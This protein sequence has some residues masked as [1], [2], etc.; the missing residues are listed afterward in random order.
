MDNLLIKECEDKFTSIIVPW[1][2]NDVVLFGAWCLMRKVPTNSLSTIGISTKSKDIS[3]KYNPNFVKTVSKEFLEFVMV[4]ETLKILL[5]HPTTRLVNPP[6]VSNIA[7]KITINELLCNSNGSSKVNDLIKESEGNKLFDSFK[8]E[9][10]QFF[11]E[12]F[13]NVIDQFDEPKEEKL[14]GMF[15]KDHGKD[16]EGCTTFGSSNE[17][18]KEYT[19]PFNDSTKEWGESK[20]FDETMKE[21]VDRHKNSSKSWGTYTGNCQGEILAATQSGV[22]YRT[23][24]SSFAQSVRKDDTYSS[25]MRYNRRHGLVVPG[26][27]K[28]EI[29]KIIVAIDESGS[30]SDADIA[31]G[32]G[33]INHVCRHSNLEYLTFDTEIKQIVKNYK[34]PKKN[35]KVFGRGGTCVDKVVRY[36]EEQR[37]DGLVIFTDGYLEP[38]QKPKNLKVLW[39]LT[40]DHPQGHFGFGKQVKLD[41]YFKS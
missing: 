2:A 34:F 29:S 24:L 9:H 10:N 35:H 6:E 32:F 28:K 15:C 5:R 38:V 13:R 17:A 37:I 40:E 39:L 4:S 11:E 30:M 25:R 23:V 31:E 19:N 21:Y 26:N 33:V 12:Y 7:S 36:A 14:K 8:V 16:S 27:R 20:E 18:S 41:R 3:L 1:M 22:N